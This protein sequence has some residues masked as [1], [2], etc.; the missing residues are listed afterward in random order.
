MSRLSRPISLTLDSTKTSFS[1][2]DA[3]NV[4]DISVS[5]LSGDPNNYP[6]DEYYTSFF[7]Y[8]SSSAGESSTRV[9]VN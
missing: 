4:P 2:D 6:F 5:I 1:V 8:A 3:I 7:V 9:Y